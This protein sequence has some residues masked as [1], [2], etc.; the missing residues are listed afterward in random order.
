MRRRDDTTTK[1]LIAAVEANTEAVRSLRGEVMSR[2][3]MID[4]K[5]DATMG[6]LTDHVNEAHGE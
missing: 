4:H 3:D 5:L 1:A 6:A 2:L